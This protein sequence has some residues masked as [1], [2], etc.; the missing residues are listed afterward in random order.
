MFDF[1]DI[2][3]C[4]AVEPQTPKIMLNSI[5]TDCLDMVCPSYNPS[6][7]YKPIPCGYESQIATSCFKRY[8]RDS[9]LSFVQAKKNNGSIGSV[10]IWD[11]DRWKSIFFNQIFTQA[12]KTDFQRRDVLRFLSSWLM[13]VLD[14]LEVKFV[15]WSSENRYCHTVEARATFQNSL[16]KI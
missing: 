9:G 6:G 2:L 4:Q 10:Y 8:S 12:R 11:L 15:N 3:G 13:L 7:P 5:R 1:A 14:A 16:Q